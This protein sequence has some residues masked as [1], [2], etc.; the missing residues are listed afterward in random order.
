[1]PKI[2]GSRDLGH[3]P[4]GKIFAYFYLGL[5][6]SSSVTNVKCL[7]SLSLVLRLCTK[8][9]VYSSSSFDDRFDCMSKILRVTWPRSRPFWENLLERPLGF[10]QMKLR[11]KFEVSSSSS[12]EDRFDCMPK[13]LGVTWPRPHA[14][15]GENYLSAR[16]AFPDEAEYQIW[17][18]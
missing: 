14:P 13:N 16:S 17:S 15:L 7:R 9:K 1:M 12:F 3:A 10:P 11:T 6:R 18:L 4:F 8:F 5:P 2:S